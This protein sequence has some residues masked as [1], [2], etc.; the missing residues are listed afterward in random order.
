MEG[1]CQN[2]E[3]TVCKGNILRSYNKETLMQLKIWMC[4]KE[5]RIEEKNLCGY[6]Q[7]DFDRQNSNDKVS[8]C[9]YMFVLDFKGAKMA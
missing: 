1:N 7:I 3:I 2:F 6:I 5:R 9:E 4:R 8:N